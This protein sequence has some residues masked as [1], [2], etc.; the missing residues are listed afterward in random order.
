MA[1][2]YS[3]LFV[4]PIQAVELLRIAVNLHHIHP[5][6][7]WYDPP[8]MLF[9]KLRGPLEPHRMGDRHKGDSK[10]ITLIVSLNCI[11]HI[12]GLGFFDWLQTGDD[13]G[14]IHRS[15]VGKVLL[16]THNW[17]GRRNSAWYV[18]L[19]ASFLALA[20][21][22]VFFAPMFLRSDSSSETSEER[23]TSSSV[24]ESH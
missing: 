3:C 24:S 6:E 12:C 1:A 21:F 5:F 2:T 15:E 23:E 9:I 13:L 11:L 20:C 18:G 10:L 14:L 19:A 22:G 17:K 8:H 4:F 7:P 16:V